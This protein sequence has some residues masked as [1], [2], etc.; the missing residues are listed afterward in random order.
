MEYTFIRVIPWGSSSMSRKDKLQIVQMDFQT[1]IGKIIPSTQE[2]F[3][4]PN[5]KYTASVRKEESESLKKFKDVLGSQ[6]DKEVSQYKQFPSIHEF[7]LFVVQY[8]AVEKDYRHR[9]IDN[10]AKTVLDVLKGR[11]YKDDSQVKTLLIGKKIEGRVPQDFAY[12][13]LKELKDGRDLDVLKVA[14]LERSITLYNDLKSRN[15]C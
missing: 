13:A 15:L 5:E 8:F 7:F 6:I 11:F 1:G 3:S 2:S 10:M 9:D 12:F 14:G 4:G